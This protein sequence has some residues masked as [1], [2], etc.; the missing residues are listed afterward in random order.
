MSNF[1]REEANNINNYKIIHTVRN[2]EDIENS[3]NSMNHVF[4]IHG[5]EECLFASVPKILE[6]YSTHYLN[7]SPL[8]KPVTILIFR[9]LFK[10]L[11]ICNFG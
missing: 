7:Q 10:I 1:I 11:N 9:Y 6:F 4:Y 2:D 5:K 8:V 3:R